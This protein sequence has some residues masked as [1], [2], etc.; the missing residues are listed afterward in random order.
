MASGSSATAT[1]GRLDG[2][3]DLLLTGLLF[4]AALIAYFPARHGGLLLDD[5]LHITR[6]E[7]QSFRG[8]WRIWFEIGATQ[9]YYPVLH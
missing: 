5:D 4:A 3:R 7:L 2:W 8:L 1:S 9:Q 6:P